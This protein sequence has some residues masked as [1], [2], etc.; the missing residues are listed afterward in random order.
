MPLTRLL[1]RGANRADAAHSIEGVVSLGTRA[2][3]ARGIGR[4]LQQ[5]E[6]LDAEEIG[7]L[8]QRLLGRTLARAV[9]HTAYYRAL[10]RDLGIEVASLT[11]PGALARFPVTDKSTLIARN[12]EFRDARIPVALMR[13][14]YS[15]GTSGTPVG[16]VRDP[17]SIAF[18]HA[19][20]HRQWRWAG[21]GEPDRR[22]VLR[23]A[24]VADSSKVTPPFWYYNVPERQ[25]VMSSYHLSEQH[26]GA[27]AQALFAFHPKVIQAYPSSVYL[28]V[29][30]LG[31][32][33][34]RRL[35]I[36]AIFTS[37]EMFP[38]GWK[39][40][41]ETAFGCKIFDFYGNAERTVAL[42]TCEVGTYHAYPD[43][44]ITEIVQAPETAPSGSVVG[45]P[46]YARAM[47]LV[48]YDSKD[49]ARFSPDRC[50]CGRAFPVIAAFDGRWDDLIVTSDG[51]Y[52]GRL[53]PIFKGLSAIVEAQIIQCD[54][55]HIA[56]HLVKGAEFEPSIEAKLRERLVMRTASDMEIE[57]VYVDA[58]PKGANGKFRTVVSH[59]PH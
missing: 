58:V 26:I 30:L 4:Q 3:I 35:G 11:E 33:Q 40:Q 44:G 54:Y 17:F 14:G 27:Y 53:D 20:I 2:A 21:V 8:Q 16:V 9:K 22:V 28:L 24:L 45:T 36:R 32:A 46:F 50:A 48:R 19:I 12:D 6:R 15:S 56:I 23:G 37:S 43:Y 18:E 55:R 41:I 59:V 13:H 34:C 7:A 10:A 57:F 38:A 25:L 1:P 29:R 5:N 52:I 39:E 31:H 51:R 42:G 47:P 49:I